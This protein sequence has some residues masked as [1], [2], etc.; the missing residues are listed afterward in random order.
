MNQNTRAKVGVVEAIKIVRPKPYS[1]NF[2]KKR[3]RPNDQFFNNHNNVASINNFNF[4]N[5][6][7]IK[8][9]FHIDKTVKL[10]MSL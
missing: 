2:E 10:N 9:N 8:T 7:L 1:S 6:S 5:N 3:Y 4:F